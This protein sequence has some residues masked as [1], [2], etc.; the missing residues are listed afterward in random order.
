M[1]NGVIVDMLKFEIHQILDQRKRVSTLRY[2]PIQQ[3][4]RAKIITQTIVKMDISSPE[5]NTTGATVISPLM[6]TVVPVEK[7][8]V[9][10]L[11]LIILFCKYYCYS[12][13]FLED[14]MIYLQSSENFRISRNA[15]KNCGCDLGAYRLLGLLWL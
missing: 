9:L 14:Y 2:G 7:T 11:R 1:I 10:N 8:K 13:N 12:F 6:P 3:I 5:R 4:I 15:P